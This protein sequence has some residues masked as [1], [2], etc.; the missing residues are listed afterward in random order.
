MTILNLTAPIKTPE[1]EK[2]EFI[3][4]DRATIGLF[5]GIKLPMQLDGGDKWSAILE[6]DAIIAF[7]SNLLKMPPGFAAEIALEQVQEIMQAA[8]PLLPPAW[9]AFLKNGK[10]TPAG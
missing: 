2:K 9:V 3:L 6:A 7:L 1:G 4:P 8:L 10:M 5:R